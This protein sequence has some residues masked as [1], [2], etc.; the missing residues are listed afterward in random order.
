MIV[1]EVQLKR[2]HTPP[3]PVVYT[4]SLIFQVNPAPSGWVY[5]SHLIAPASLLLALLLSPWLPYSNSKKPS[6]PPSQA[7]CTCP[8]SLPGVFYPWLLAGL[9]TLIPAVSVSL[10]PSQGDCHTQAKA[11]F[12]WKSLSEHS[13]LSLHCT[14]HN[15]KLHVYLFAC[16]SSLLTKL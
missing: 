8:C 13:T 5:L 15:L 16:F 4:K 7:L 12:L 2:T 6:S 9:A 14:S 3:K 10:L 11:S 1:T